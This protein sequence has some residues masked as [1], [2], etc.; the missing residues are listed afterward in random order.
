[1]F[2]KIAIGV[3]ELD[4]QSSHTGQTSLSGALVVP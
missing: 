4:P 2:S 1:M 3:K